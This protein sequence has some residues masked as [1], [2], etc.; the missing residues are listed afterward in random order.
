MQKLF[1]AD[2]LDIVPIERGFVYAC[3]ET[4]PEGNEAVAFYSYNQEI[5]IFEKIPVL[6]YINSKFGENGVNIARSL[7]DFVTC[8]LVNLTNS[9]KAVAYDDGT[10]KILGS[11]GETVSQT[12][13][14]YL[15][16]PACS[17]VVNGQDLWFVVPDSNAIINYSVKHNRIEFR[18]GSPKEKAFCHPT[19]LSIYDNKLFICNAYSYKIRT[20][21]LDNYTVA[22]YCIFNEPVLKYFRV[23]DI[24]YTVMQSGVYSL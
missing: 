11:I 3:K 23:K 17:P 15:D 7:G 19:D 18:I 16:N 1:N 8:D 10:F 12:K 13:V 6:S 21:S 5:D 24:E 22:D 2:L 14:E 4:L 20:I 9:T